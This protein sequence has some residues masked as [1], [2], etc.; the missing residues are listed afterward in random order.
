M[1]NNSVYT[2][3]NFQYFLPYCFPLCL[4]FGGR[5]EN[6]KEITKINHKT[7]LG[8]VLLQSILPHKLLLCHGGEP[9][10]TTK[11]DPERVS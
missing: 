7:S 4:P 5:N 2:L 6:K 1:E 11:C 3:C 10:G 9:S 8:G